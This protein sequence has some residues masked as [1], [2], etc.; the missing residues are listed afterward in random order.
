MSLQFDGEEIV[1]RAQE[2]KAF[3]LTAR[4]W[5]GS[6]RL[7]VGSDSWLAT[8]SDGKLASFEADREK[9]AD[10]LVAGP[11]HAWQE[12]LRGQP[13]PGYTDII[14]ASLRGIR[15]EGD[16]VEA[17]GPYYPAVQ[18]LIGILR[19]SRHGSQKVALDDYPF[20]DS[21]VARC[22]YVH[23][24]V[25]GV[26]YRIFVQEAGEGIPLLLQHG[27]GA[28]SRQW[29]HLL[30]DPDL[31]KRFRMIAY[32]LPYHGKSLPP[33]GIRWWQNEYRVTKSDL[34][35]RAVAISRALGLDRPIFMGCSMGGQLALDLA[36]HHADDF[37]AF[38][39]I[40][41]FYHQDALVGPLAEHAPAFASQYFRHPRIHEEYFAAAVYGSTSPHAPERT[42]REAQWIAASNGLGIY[43]GDHDYVMFGHDLR[44][45]GHLIDARRTPLWIVAGEYDASMLVPDGGAR[46]LAENIAGAELRILPNLSHS[47]ISDDPLGFRRQIIPI[48]DEVSAR[49]AMPVS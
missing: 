37:S 17:V 26:E 11:E 28:D 35:K 21:D 2:D 7:E 3:L 8:I 19:E 4:K 18:R 16:P 25:D 13:G 45:D 27:E 32:D 49:I 1:M 24:D 33:E 34:M 46:S 48:L 41:G 6:V 22:H 20:R 39:A 31:Q 42:R 38:V 23:T 36:A 10:I 30:A 44:E 12:L 14:I 5:T 40:N 15:L 47:M 9:A 43:K 29:R